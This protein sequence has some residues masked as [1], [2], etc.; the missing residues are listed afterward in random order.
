MC[1]IAGIFNLNSKPVAFDQIKAMMDSIAHCGPDGQ[2]QFTDKYIGLGH[3]RLAIIDLSP[4]G[5][6]PMQTK[7]GRYLITYNGEVYNFKILRKELVNLGYSFFS[8]TDTEVV[9]N[10]YVQW[11][12]KCLENF[13]GMFAF[14]VWD[15]KEKALFLARDRYGIKPLYYYQTNDCFVFSSEIKAIISSG[16]YGTEINKEAL[17]EYLTF[18]NFYGPNPFKRSP[19]YACRSFYDGKKRKFI[20][21]SILGF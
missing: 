5:H 8:N 6:Q 17:L 1:G 18:Q 10:A 16:L 14:A 19:Y 4:A 13:N 20:V 7:D 9:L 11:G 12:E 3:R 2:G 15:R 21:P